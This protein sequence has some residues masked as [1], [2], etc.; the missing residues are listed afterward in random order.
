MFWAVRRS[1]CLIRFT[2]IFGQGGLYQLN[3]GVD[4]QVIWI[5]SML[6]VMPRASRDRREVMIY[7]TKRVS[8]RITAV[9]SSHPKNIKEIKS[10]QDFHGVPKISAHPEEVKHVWDMCSNTCIFPP[11]PTPPRPFCNHPFCVMITADTNPPPA[12]KRTK[13]LIQMATA[14]Q[15]QPRL[16]GGGGGRRGDTSWLEGG[17]TQNIYV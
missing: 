11:L 4:R 14:F 9:F 10:I 6:P 3:L 15:R 8:V 17:K 1:S 13:T 2:S 16:S 12:C 7:W 5:R